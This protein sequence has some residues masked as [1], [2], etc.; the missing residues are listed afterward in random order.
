MTPK[1]PSGR[2]SSI[3]PSRVRRSS[4]AISS[5][6]FEIDGGSLAALVGF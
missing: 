2:I 1:R 6:D 5:D 3:W 4:F